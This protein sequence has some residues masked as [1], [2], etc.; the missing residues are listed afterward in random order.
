M[1][2][3]AR[4]TTATL[5]AWTQELSAR[6]FGVAFDGRVEWAPRL[7]SRAGDYLAS[8]RRIRVSAPYFD[9]YGEGE[10]RATLLHELCHWWLHREGVR[11]RENS[12]RFQD[13]LRAVG[14]P[15]YAAPL[16]PRRFYRCPRCGARFGYGRRVSGYA[17][18]A[19]CRRYAGG[20]Y[21]P[22]FM[23]VEEGTRPQPAGRS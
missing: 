11:H 22:R 4:P 14:A 7:R 6:H 17:C 20:R 23:L 8:Q 13:L 21:D 2:T 1:S 3:P 15:R 16:E 10:A 9:R 5:A 18:A 12:R 19:C